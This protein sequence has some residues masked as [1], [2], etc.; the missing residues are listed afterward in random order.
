MLKTLLQKISDVFGYRLDEITNDN[1]TL[2]ITA[3]IEISVLKEE[4]QLYLYSPIT[5]AP[6][7]NQEE[8]Y[9]YLMKANLLGQGTGKTSIGLDNNDKFLTLSYVMPYEETYEN[10]KDKLELFVN[11]LFF[12]K[13]EVKKLQNK[14]SI[15]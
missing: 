3:E 11:Y 4:E 1:F 14:K 9:T 6:L 8:I 12:W 10:F 15:Y 2:T 5:L 13:D 7:D